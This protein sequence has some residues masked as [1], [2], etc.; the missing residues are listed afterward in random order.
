MTTIQAERKVR[1]PIAMRRRDAD[2]QADQQPEQDCD[3]RDL[4]AVIR[5]AHRSAGRDGLPRAELILCLRGVRALRPLE[6]R[7]RV[8][9]RSGGLLD[10]MLERGV[11]GC[12]GPGSRHRRRR[13]SS[14]LALELPE[15]RL[16]A[17][18]R[19]GVGADLGQERGPA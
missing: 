15:M 16:S 19:D 14:R 9:H 7:L 13:L 3:L 2:G 18:E 17:S 6:L 4:L 11:G 1:D 8:G 12:L 10:L 5:R